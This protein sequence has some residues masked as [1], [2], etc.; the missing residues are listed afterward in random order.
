MFYDIDNKAERL[1]KIEIE[2]EGERERQT[3]SEIRHMHIVQYI[4]S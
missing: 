1:R 4:I 2:R 3:E